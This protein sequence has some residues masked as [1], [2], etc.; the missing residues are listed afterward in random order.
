MNV[1]LSLADFVQQTE[2]EVVAV[3]INIGLIVFEWQRHTLVGEE[4]HQ[5]FMGIRQAQI[6]LFGKLQHR[7]FR[8]LIEPA[9]ADIALFA[10]VLSEEEVED[11]AYNRYEYKHQHPCHGLFGLPVFHENAHHCGNYNDDVEGKYYPMCVD[12]SYY[13][14]SFFFCI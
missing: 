12:H 14:A 5:C 8:Q 3:S 7:T 4:F 2:D 9:L 1:M 11:N 10:S 6:A 13:F